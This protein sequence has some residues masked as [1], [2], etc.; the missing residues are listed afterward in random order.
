MLPVSQALT[1]KN[2]NFLLRGMLR[3]PQNRRNTRVSCCAI[4]SKAP[5]LLAR[6]AVCCTRLL[7]DGTCTVSNERC[8]MMGTLL[9][10]ADPGSAFYQAAK[11]GVQRAS[12]SLNPRAPV[13]RRCL[14]NNLC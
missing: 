12:D 7:E 10:V 6:L 14:V 3:E 8:T 13:I 2:Q 11:R 4:I 5:S 9:Y 1:A